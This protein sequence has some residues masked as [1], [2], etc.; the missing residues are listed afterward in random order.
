MKKDIEIPIVENVHL[1]IAQEW[2]KE[3]LGK[4]WNAYLINDRTTA[5]ETVLI[6]SKGFN[7]DIKT[8]TMRQHFPVVGPKSAVK[9]ELVQ[10]EILQLNNQYDVT[11]FADGKLYERTFLFESGTISENKLQ[12]VPI[13]NLEGILAK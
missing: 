3:F 5:I 11:F 9:I 6:V 12:H 10:E 7:G 1:A 2:N 8:S 4:E 13:V